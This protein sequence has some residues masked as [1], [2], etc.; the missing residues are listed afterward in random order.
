[1]NACWSGQ[2]KGGETNSAQ[3][4]HSGTEQRGSRACLGI[5]SPESTPPQ[6]T[7]VK[8]AFTGT[9]KKH[10]KA[11]KN[12]KKTSKMY[13]K[14]SKNI[15]KTSKKHQKNIKKTS[16]NIKKHQKKSKNIKKDQKNIKNGS[17]PLFEAGG[18]TYFVSAQTAAPQHAD[19]KPTCP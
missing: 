3:P 6:K 14:T 15:K 1:M 2:E 11:S 4:K 16:K 7:H 5:S 19:K 17:T 8:G 10:Q 9:P 13:Q 18:F 12:I